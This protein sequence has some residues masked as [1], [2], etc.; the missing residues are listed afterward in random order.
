MK[1]RVQ[2][3]SK[4]ALKHWS[5]SLAS[6]TSSPMENADRSNSLMEN[7]GMFCILNCQSII[8]KGVFKHIVFLLQISPV[9][10]LKTVALKPMIS[11]S[12]TIVTL[13]NIEDSAR[14]LS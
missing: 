2:D 10:N 7:E 14:M 1:T 4:T 12:M 3:Q 9:M 6:M 13:L 5:D 8:L 11:R